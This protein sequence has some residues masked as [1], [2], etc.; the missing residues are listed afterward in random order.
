MVTE[1]GYATGVTPGREVT[2]EI[3]ARY[4]A[5]MLLLHFKAGI[6]RTFIYQFADS[7][8]DTGTTSAWSTPMGSRSLRTSRFPDC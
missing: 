6:R 8:T 1:G 3:Q 2:P 5:R 4:I 7:G